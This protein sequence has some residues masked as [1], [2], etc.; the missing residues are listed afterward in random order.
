M[1]DPVV[2]AG[3]ARTPMGGMQGALAP[4]TAPDLGAVAIKSA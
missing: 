1:T 4:A 3:L 2:I